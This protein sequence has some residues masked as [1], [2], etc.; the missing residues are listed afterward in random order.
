MVLSLENNIMKQ[1]YSEA[2]ANL[3]GYTDN[4]IPDKSTINSGFYPPFFGGIPEMT[5]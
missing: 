1:D 3:L 4:R 2:I 5:G